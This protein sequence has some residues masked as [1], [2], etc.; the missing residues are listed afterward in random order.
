MLNINELSSHNTLSL[1]NSQLAEGTNANT[2]KTVQAIDF[3]IGEQ[4]YSKAVTDNIAMTAAAQQ[5]A[6]TSCMYLITINS[7]GTV[8]V[9]KGTEQVTGSGQ[10][11]LWPTVPANE[12]VIGAIKIAT[13]AATTFTSGSTDLS[14]AGITATYYNY[15]ALPSF[16]LQA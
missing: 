2:I 14:A 10:P 3:M 5:A 1:G 6:L 8:K 11:L 13:A 7:S 12:A 4:L 9:T 16:V 15:M